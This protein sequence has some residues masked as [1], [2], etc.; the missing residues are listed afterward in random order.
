MSSLTITNTELKGYIG[1]FLGCGDA[2]GSFVG[3]QSD[4]VSRCLAE[5]KR[6]FYANQN[7]HEWSFLTV[8]K[9]FAL[10]SGVSRYDLPA[11]FSTLEGPIVYSANSSLLYRPITI[12]SDVRVMQAINRS[13]DST[14]VPYMAAV[15]SK[16]NNEGAILT[17]ALYEL[18][19]YPTPADD[20][21]LD[22]RYKINPLAPTGDNVLPIGDQFHVQTLIEAC[23]AS[24]ERFQGEMNGVHEIEFQKRLQASITY[25]QRKIAPH[26]LG[27]LVDHS[28]GHDYCPN[29]SWRELYL[30]TVTPPAEWGSIT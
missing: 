11:D 28:D 5:G 20:Y 18:L 1:R 21:E 25:D 16:N 14:S 2:P 15:R 27:P 24:A 30:T 22:L 7:A 8:T 13:G 9:T 19:V 12:T 17:G 6:N 4:D 23:L 10:A 3:E 29:G 26:S